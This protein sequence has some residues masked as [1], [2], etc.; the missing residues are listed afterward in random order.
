MNNRIVT[1]LLNVDPLNNELENKNQHKSFLAD[2]SAT[3]E[4]LHNFDKICKDID[5]FR[6]QNDEEG[7]NNLFDFLVTS[8]NFNDDIFSHPDI[9]FN[10]QKHIDQLFEL[11]MDADNFICFA[12]DPKQRKSITYFKPEQIRL[13]LEKVVMPDHFQYLV[14]HFIDFKFWEEYC[15]KHADLFDKM[16]DQIINSHKF[17]SI[18][19]SEENLINIAQDKNITIDQKNKLF[20]QFKLNSSM[21]LNEKNLHNL[22]SAFKEY[23]DGILDEVLIPERMHMIS[24]LFTHIYSFSRLF[25]KPQMQRIYDFV[26]KPEHFKI[27][28]SKSTIYQFSLSC[29]DEDHKKQLFFMLISNFNHLVFNKDLLNRLGEVFTGYDFI[30]KQPTL[31]QARFEARKFLPE[32][33]EYAKV[34]IAHFFVK[35]LRLPSDIGFN[36]ASFWGSS[37]RTVAGNIALTSKP[38]A[39]HASAAREESLKQNLQFRK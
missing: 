17:I 27:I 25:S 20:D 6:E 1:S 19:H 30:F 32:E 15:I 22:C 28:I 23:I 12:S 39:E 31:K 9:F 18:I 29:K 11:I 37:K 7:E 35:N 14:H 10:N 21:F 16:I 5:S 36:V 34:A 3:V 13:I 26:L 8:G 33:K 4:A 38:I 24:S 2:L